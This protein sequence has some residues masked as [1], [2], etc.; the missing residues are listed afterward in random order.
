V[1]A[2]LEFDAEMLAPRFRAAEAALALVVR[3][4]RI[5]PTVMLQTFLAEHDVVRAAVAG[6]PDV[7]LR[8]ERSRRRS[9]ELPPFSALAR[10]TGSGAA[11]FAGALRSVE[12]V[13]AVAVLGGD[14]ALVKATDHAALSDA[15]G[16][17]ERPP[18]VR[19]A[20]DPPRA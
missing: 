3:A 6:D 2:F 19:V 7:V 4:G 11:E 1:V 18:G 12:G 16:G 8:G 5:A 17:T 9:L 13:S 10:C 14:R 20:V 15:L